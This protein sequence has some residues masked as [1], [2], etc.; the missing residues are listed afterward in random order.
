VRQ[1]VW[2]HNPCSRSTT[3]VAFGF[4]DRQEDRLDAD[5]Q[6]QAHK[7]A[8]QARHFVA[9]VESRIVVQLQPV[10]QT[11]LLPSGQCVCPYSCARFVGVQRLRERSG[12][13]IHAVE[14]EQ[15]GT[16]HQV[17]RRP[18]HRVQHVGRASCRLWEIAALGWV[19]VVDQIGIVQD[20]F[21]GCQRGNTLEQVGV[22]QFVLDGLGA[23]QSDASFEQVLTGRHNHLAR[24][25]GVASVGV[26]RSAGASAQA[27]PAQ[28]VES[29]QPFG[30]PG[31][32]APDASENSRSF[33]TL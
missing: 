1:K 25:V 29:A 19:W 9:T 31:R 28:F 22:M 24:V 17:A 7:R 5:V 15:L 11:D 20:A 30:Q 13:Y 3:L 18:V 32:A 27:L 2:L 14:N 33:A 16:I 6:T 12:L 26:Q 21:D 4:A 10:R 8:K 23:A